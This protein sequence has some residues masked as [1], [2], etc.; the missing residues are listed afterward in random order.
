MRRALAVLLMV[1]S[2]APLA[3]Q[4]GIAWHKVQASW[5]GR[6]MRGT[7]DSVITAI[8]FKFTGKHKVT[9]KYRNRASLPARV[10]ASGG[11][12]IVVDY[13]PYSSLTRAGHTVT[14]VHNVL[15]VNDDRMTGTF[16]ATFEDGQT[17]TGHVEATRDAAKA[18]PK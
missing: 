7:S 11:D 3:A 10:M 15:H 13:G 5:T 14:L 1:A 8:A 4:K 17:L 18:K 16:T 2:A 6:S 12:S 9:A